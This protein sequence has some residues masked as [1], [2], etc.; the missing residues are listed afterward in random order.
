MTMTS[1]ALK[2]IYLVFWNLDVKELP[3]VADV[4]DGLTR[5]SLA[6][7]RAGDISA[8]TAMRRAAESIRDKTS[9]AKTFTSRET[10]RTRTQIDSIEEQDGRLRRSFVGQYE[11]DDDDCPQHIAGRPLADF[12]PAFD[13]AKSHYSG[14]DLS[15]VVQAI[16][17]KDGLGA[18][19]PKKYGG[20]Y[21]VPVKPEAADLL[22]RIARFTETFGVRF[23]TY[24]IPDTSA[25]REE[26]AEAIANTYADQIAEHASAI[27]S[28]TVDTL[29]F[30][31][32][33]RHEAIKAT[34]KGMAKLQNLM[35]GRYAESVRRLEELAASLVDLENRQTAHRADVARE[36]RQAGGR[37]ILT[38]V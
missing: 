28:Y 22:D 4:R 35:N 17:E 32:T 34:E 3:S 2:D 16:L 29:T 11:V 24:T 38:N 10:N 14:A 27:A 25:Q 37:R 13:H 8:S 36:Q 26:I 7:E 9:E 31:F 6:P 1:T 12:I 19:S 18:F 21:F 15:K 20:V 30:V 33:N 23:L 5:N